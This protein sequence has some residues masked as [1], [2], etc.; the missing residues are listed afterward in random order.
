MSGLIAAEG[1]V[2][3]NEWF[4]IICTYNWLFDFEIPFVCLPVVAVAVVE[5]DAVDYFL[6][7]YYGS[8]LTEIYRSLVFPCSRAKWLG[9][10]LGDKGY[11]W[12]TADDWFLQLEGTV[13]EEK[14]PGSTKLFF[15][16]DKDNSFWMYYSYY[17]WGCCC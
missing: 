16:E 10:N 4:G 5:G 2:V 1:I 9:I 12:I 15:F 14:Q 6:D 13:K 11:V 17:C 7:K 8:W 3:W